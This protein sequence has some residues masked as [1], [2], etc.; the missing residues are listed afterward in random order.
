MTA[1]TVGRLFG[2]CGALRAGNHLCLRGSDQRL[3]RGILRPRRCRPR[4]LLAGDLGLCGIGL[5]LNCIR[6]NL[7]IGGPGGSVVVAGH[8][9]FSANDSVGKH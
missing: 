8:C 1:G 6:R 2:Q 5:G 3:Q 4:L 7:A 9:G